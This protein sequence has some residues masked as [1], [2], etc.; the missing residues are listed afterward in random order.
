[1]L[2]WFWC[3]C[4]LFGFVRCAGA[5]FRRMM[6]CPLCHEVVFNGE[7]LSRRS[8]ADNATSQGAAGRT[9]PCPIC[10]SAVPEFLLVQPREKRSG[11]HRVASHPQQQSSTRTYTISICV[12]AHCAR[13]GGDPEAARTNARANRVVAESQR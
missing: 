12:F 6:E 9:E 13:S 4:V 2:L 10:T 5:W 8:D 1:M 3:V 11:A 7:W